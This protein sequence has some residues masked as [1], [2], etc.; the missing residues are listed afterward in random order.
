MLEKRIAALEAQV[1]RQQSYMPE[2]TAH[3]LK[4]ILLE[5]LSLQPFENPKES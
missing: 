4:K 3:C 5:Q 1:Q 2:F